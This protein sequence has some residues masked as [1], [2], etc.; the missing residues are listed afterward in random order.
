MT[1]TASRRLTKICK[2]GRCRC[3]RELL[4]C[5]TPW[6]SRFLSTRN[7]LA[8]LEHPDQEKYPGQRISMVQVDDCVYA[9]C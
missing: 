6:F 9:I 5:E 1:T 4:V 8:V 7:E 3:C 2:Q